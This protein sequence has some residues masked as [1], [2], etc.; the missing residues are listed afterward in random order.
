MRSIMMKVWMFTR[1]ACVC[2]KWPPQNIP[3]RSVLDLHKFTKKLFR[4]EKIYFTNVFKGNIK[5]KLNFVNLSFQ[6]VR[7]NSFEK[8]ETADIK[9]IIDQ[10]IRLNKEERPGVKELLN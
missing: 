6:G 5:T 7:P 8:I 2:W 4:Y 1:S 9:E 3:I 10:C